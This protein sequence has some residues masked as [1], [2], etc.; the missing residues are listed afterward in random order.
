MTLVISKFALKKEKKKK[1]I[2]FPYELK[3]KFLK[4]K[5]DILQLNIF[6]P[7][8]CVCVTHK[9]IWI[10]KTNTEKSVYCE[11][12]ER[13]GRE[14]AMIAVSQMLLNFIIIIK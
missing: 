13:D 1:E 4:I 9:K 3:F 12:K 6:K 11:G 10:F 8:V 14:S 7:R 2:A 5:K